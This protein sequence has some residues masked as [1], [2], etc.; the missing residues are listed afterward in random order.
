MNYII[1]YRNQGQN[2]LPETAVTEITEAVKNCNAKVF[3]R[4]ATAIRK[5][6]QSELINNGWSL[7]VQIDPSSRVSITSRKAETG[8]CIQT[9]NVARVYADLLKLQTV[10]ERGLIKGGG[11]ILPTRDCARQLASNMANLERL[12]NEL[13]IFGKV[14]N[15][16]LVLIGI[17]E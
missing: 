3:L 4:N 13:D 16:P 17:Y 1:V 7:E 10:F 14:I 5:K 12:D 15:L 11:I 8:L 2:V 9:G 6:I